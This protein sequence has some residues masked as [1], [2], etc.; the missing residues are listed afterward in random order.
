MRRNAAS[1]MR[2]GRHKGRRENTTMEKNA[3]KELR[4]EAREIVAGYDP[5]C[6]EEAYE[7]TVLKLAAIGFRMAAAGVPCAVGDGI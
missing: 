4:A 7:N 6:G 5:A 3:M 2:A 1:P